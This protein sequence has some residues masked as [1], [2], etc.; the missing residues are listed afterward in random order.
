M[1][2]RIPAL[3]FKFDADALQ[4]RNDFGSPNTLVSKPI[5]L[6]NK[7]YLHG[8]LKPAEDA[9]TLA[10][11]VKQMQKAFVHR[12]S[13]VFNVI[14][15]KHFAVRLQL[16]E[17]KSESQK[18]TFSIAKRGKKYYLVIANAGDSKKHNVAID[19]YL[20]AHCINDGI[21]LFFK[22]INVMLICDSMHEMHMIKNAIQNLK[23]RFPCE[24]CTQ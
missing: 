20:G 23:N 6:G 8:G 14:K 21:K 22:D 3:S 19:G 24:V 5:C 17:T 2:L 4:P 12:C 1:S 7:L 16:P 11:F 9:K 15:Q 13:R 18:A 10:Y